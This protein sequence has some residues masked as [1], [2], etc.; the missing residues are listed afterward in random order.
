MK[1]NDYLSEMETGKLAS[2]KD[3]AKRLGLSIVVRRTHDVYFTIFVY[4]KR[5][6]KS[7]MVGFDGCFL[8]DKFNFSHCLKQTEEWISGYVKTITN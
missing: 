7:Y 6:K 3:L 4:D 5:V 1:L 2:V 8:D